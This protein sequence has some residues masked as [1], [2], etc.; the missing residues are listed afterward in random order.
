MGHYRYNGSYMTGEEYARCGKR[1]THVAEYPHHEPFYLCRK[2]AKIRCYVREL[3]NDKSSATAGQKTSST[4]EKPR[5]PF[6]AAYG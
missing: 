1:A 4:E 2:H 3:P 6:A 5:P